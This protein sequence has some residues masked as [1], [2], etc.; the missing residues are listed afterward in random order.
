MHVEYDSEANILSFELGGGDITYAKE[1]S[2]TIIH[3]TEGNKPVLIEVL[4]AS[5]FISKLGKLKKRGV[6][7]SPA[8]SP[9]T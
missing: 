5:H 4:Q 3:F 6:V 9:T 1:Y 7:I 8:S 2:G